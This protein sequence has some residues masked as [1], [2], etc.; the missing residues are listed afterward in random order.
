MIK[1]YACISNKKITNIVI[2]DDEEIKLIEDLKVTFEYDEIVDT[3]DNLVEVGWGY[4][5]KIF[6][7][8]EINF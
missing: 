8:P 6:I 4:E 5:D 3:E 2:I 7:K 1:S